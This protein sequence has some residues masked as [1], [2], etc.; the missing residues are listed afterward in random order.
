[1]S[2]VST[3]Y[4]IYLLALVPLFFMYKNSLV[5]RDKTK[6]RLSFAARALG[7]FLLVLAL[8]RPFLEGQSDDK[9]LIFLFDT[10]HSVDLAK[11]KE[12]AGTVLKE[13]EDFSGSE[14]ADIYIFAKKLIPVE[15]ANLLSKLAEIEKNISDTKDR[16]ESLISASMAISRLH[17]PAGKEKILCLFS[18]G[19]ETA[20]KSLNE[21]MSVLEQEGIKTHFSMLPGTK[22]NETS[23]SAFSINPP[24]AYQG[25]TV[26]LKATIKSNCDSKATVAFSNN[27]IKLHSKEIE[28]KKD[29][30][31][32]VFADI[33]LTKEMSKDWQVEIEADKDSFPMNNTRHTSLSILGQSKILALH[34]KPAKLNYF[35]RALAK[36]GID[37][38]VRNHLGIPATLEEFNQFNAVIVADVPATKMTQK[39][40]KTI[41]SYVEDCGGGFIMTGSSNSFGLGGYYK[42]PIEEILPVSSKFEKDKE[43]PSLSLVLVID[44]SGSMGGIPIELARQASKASVDILGAKDK[45]AVI[46]FDGSAHTVVEMQSASSKMSIKE[47]IESIQASGGTNLGP[48]MQAGQEM[49]QSSTSKLKH[50]IILSDGQ[51][52]AADFEGIA[53]E[54]SSSG[55]T[56]ST[57]SLGSGAAV[58]LMAHIAEIG[59][60]RAYVTN[61][62]MDM[63][64]I[65]TKETMEAS[66]TAIKEEPFMPIAGQE[67][68]LFAQIDLEEAPFLLG[69]V[70]T[71]LKPATNVALLTEQGDPLLVTSSFGIGKS[72]AF[73]SD[74]CDV[75]SSEWLE[76][77]QY[78]QF[79][80]Q[81]IR[82]LSSEQSQ[83]LIRTAF[84][85]TNGQKSLMISAFDK[86]SQPESKLS[87]NASLI[88]SQ[89]QKKDLKV[90][91]AGLGK[92]LCEYEAPKEGSYTIRLHDQSNNRIKNVFVNDNYPEEYQL[93]KNLDAS[94]QNLASFEGLS[95]IKSSGVQSFDSAFDQFLIVA[96]FFILLSI[97]LRRI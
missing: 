84:Q 27:G 33:A 39:Q 94:L 29:Q 82:S 78:G 71:K 37:L 19:I 88:D 83:Q 34:E 76:W 79:W 53:N 1:M 10:S 96:I 74:L 41:R 42:T 87:W 63:P 51:S 58:G 89:G 6:K 18:D 67:K 40:M 91:A 90:Q 13:I 50:M 95:K 8:C 26:R 22:Q 28:L 72:V 9:H 24:Y 47:T 61:D 12:S 11:L 2:F 46:A 31:Q 30:T 35:R 62:P 43:H 17:F 80:A 55:I 54:M 3:K 65:F 64:Q 81:I 21:T 60:G 57:V 7:V 44:K 86:L 16:S 20:E 93:N 32:N 5:N 68:S 14:T 38:E 48:A 66:S 25:E 85:E 15:P 4:L 36:Q 97:L 92:Y 52:S 69:Y 49:L 59:R 73:T 23:I 70:M 45:V 75:W 77:E 56:I